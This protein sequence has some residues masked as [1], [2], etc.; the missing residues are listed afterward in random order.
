MTKYTT[1]LLALSIFLILPAHVFAEDADTYLIHASEEQLEQITKQY[2]A[3]LKE[4]DEIPLVEL[5]LT[6][7]EKVS[8]KGRFST[9][10]IYPNQVYETTADIVSPSF[11]TTKS[12]PVLAAPFT[13]SGIRVGVLDTG[14]DTDHSDIAVAGGVCTA[15]DCG[16]K[17][18]YDDNFGH[19]T[20][21]AGIIAAKKNN[22]GII[23]IAPNVKLFAIKAM[24]S[25]G[26][27]T[28]AQ[29][30]KGV[31]WAIKNKI[32]ILNLSLS[33]S[34]HDRPLELMLQEASKKGMLIV[35]AAGNEGGEGGANTVTYPGKYSTVIAVSALTSDL[36]REQHSST[37][38]EVE[39]A[40]PGSNIFSTFPR[41]LDNADYVV[42][43][44][45][46]L[47]GT[48]MAAPHVTGILA[49]YKEQHPALSHTKLREILRSTAKD[50]GPAGRDI[51]F[52]YGLVQ[53]EK[54]IK[55]VP[56]IETKVV[57]GKIS[58]TLKNKELASNWTIK[59]GTTTLAETEPGKWVMYKTKGTYPL[60][61]SYTDKNGA[62]KNEALTIKVNEPAFPDVTMAL[63]YAPHISYLYSN[64][65]MSGYL[66]GTFK[67]NRE[68]KRGEA[69]ILLGRAQG[70]NG[71]SRNTKFTDVG[72]NHSA[73]GYIQS[74]Y[75]KGLIQGYP[76]GSFRPDQSVTRAEMALLIQSVYQFKF[77]PALAP[78]FKDVH[79][80]Q[81]SY[82]AI[83]A[84]TQ[85]KITA[86]YSS[87]AFAPDKMMNR[88]AFA[89]FLA[90][91]KNPAFI[92]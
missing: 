49:L 11:T 66:D 21:V 87:T 46:N 3:I 75:E 37:G 25:K 44:Y 88:Y 30:T 70:F 61:F 78:P 65:F 13:G 40:A 84:I 42:D 32:D 83:Q 79:S 5:R 33:I 91:A 15:D 52:G 28:T 29:V 85:N 27:G 47:T 77:D 73:S 17:I 67:P 90:R 23:G 35:G 64:N 54:E 24:D 57:K 76:D 36:K 86:G 82:K 68:I 7:E 63:W 19:G 2:T 38:P 74:A 10:E 50:I 92:K 8:L 41:E 14:I 43:G 81:A 62:K 9:A 18:P 4:Y 58:L 16:A 6:E 71:T 22:A 20:H 80:E 56:L 55:T 1:M 53:Y 12:S 26:A 34:E 59:E 60:T 48:S 89:V 31:E 39:I 51:S 72:A 45:Q 69:M